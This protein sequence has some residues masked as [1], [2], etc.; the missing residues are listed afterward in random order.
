MVEDEHPD[1]VSTLLGSAPA[2]ARAERLQAL[3]RAVTVLADAMAVLLSR[4]GA[5]PR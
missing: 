2:L 1:M 4:S 3:G 5:A